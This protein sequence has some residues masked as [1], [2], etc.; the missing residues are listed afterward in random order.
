MSKHIRTDTT[1]GGKTDDEKFDYYFPD[2]IYVLRWV[3]ESIF[4]S[5]HDYKNGTYCLSNL[6]N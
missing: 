2:F 1:S 5:E 4:K 6:A 3:R